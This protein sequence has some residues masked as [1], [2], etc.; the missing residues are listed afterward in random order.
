MEDVIVSVVQRTM[1]AGT[2]LL[3]GTVG[4]VICERSGIL[5]LGVEG[6]MS[7]G[8]VVAFIV[9]YSTGDPW[10]A[11]VAAIGAGMI[12]S[13]L[14]AFA[15]V[16]LQANQ[17]VSGLALTMI[18]LG[19][20]GMLGKQYVGKPLAVKMDDIAIPWLSDI[21]FIGTVFFKQTPYFYMAVFLALGAWFFLERTRLGIKVRSTGENPRATETQG[22]NVA[23]IR[24]ACVIIGGGFSAMAGAHLSTSYSKS[25]IEGMTAGRGWIV[26]ALTIFA[27]WNPGRAIWGAFIFGGIFVLQYLLQ[28]LGISPNFLAMLPYGSTLLILLVMS[29]KDPRRLNA[30]AQLGEPYKRGER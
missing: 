4:E 27:L 19:L 2:P 13:I 23:R 7:V 8:A 3:L 9:T 18:G 30:P 26:I 10:L 6:V 24:Y 29:F 16:T 5:N 1:V 11:M 17:V 25:W 12:I 28:P 21:P 20:S 15:S 22:V 14:H